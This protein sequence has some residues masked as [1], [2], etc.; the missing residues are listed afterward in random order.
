MKF[1]LAGADLTDNLRVC[2]YIARILL[3]MARNITQPIRS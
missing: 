3:M 1:I 2:L